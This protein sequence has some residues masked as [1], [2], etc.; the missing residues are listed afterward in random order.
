MALLLCIKRVLPIG[1]T[2]LLKITP[3]FS[4]LMFA[5]KL[6]VCMV[7]WEKSRLPQQPFPEG[8]RARITVW[9]QTWEMGRKGSRIPPKNLR[10]A[11]AAPLPVA[12]RVTFSFTGEVGNLPLPMQGFPS[13]SRVWSYVVASQNIYRDLIVPQGSFLFSA[14]HPPPPHTVHL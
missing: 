10:G 12:S 7:D 14:R 2:I 9:S 5:W 11:S 8:P 6:R 3:L 4:K 13:H 1:N